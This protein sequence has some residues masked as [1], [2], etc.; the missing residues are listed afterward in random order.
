ME[1]CI[2]ICNRKK[3]AS[4]R[5]KVIF[6]DAVNEVTRERAQSFLKPENQQR[7]LQAFKNFA[8]MRGFSKVATLAEIGGNGGNLS[9]PLY[10]KRVAVATTTDSNG[11]TASLQFAWNQWQTDGRAFW[12]KMDA[13]METLDGLA[14][15]K[16][17]TEIILLKQN[18]KKTVQPAFKRAVLA[19]EIVHQLHGEQRFGSVKLEKLLFLTEKHFGLEG[20]MQSRY[21]R[22][23]AGPYDPKAMRSI[24]SNLKSHKW[25]D[26]S[27]V[28]GRTHYTPMEKS[29]Q[30]AHYYS[31]YFAHVHARIHLLIIRLKTASTEQCEIVAT[32]YSAWADLISKNEPFADDDIIRDVTQNWHPNKQLIETARWH[33]ALI[34][35]RDHRLTPENQGELV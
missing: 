20:D 15:N 35:M 9:I 27:K 19:A 31:R 4:R 2:L 33:E 30:H 34:W 11:V 12:R 24:V 13:L 7:I 22:Q 14:T 25:F 26:V 16:P 6:I 18:I 28:N 10:V 8:D 23:A 17:I 1:S 5:G 29:G 3:T 21:Y 32:L